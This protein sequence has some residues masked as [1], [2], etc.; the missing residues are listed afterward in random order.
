MNK[1]KLFYFVKLYLNI[2]QIAAKDVFNLYLLPSYV[3]KLLE[4][5]VEVGVGV[6][7]T[8]REAIWTP[9]FGG[10]PNMIVTVVNFAEYQLY[11]DKI[12]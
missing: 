5:F 1:K 8:K 10:V 6:G 3:W 2:I 12:V 11:S 9:A 7:V 4:G